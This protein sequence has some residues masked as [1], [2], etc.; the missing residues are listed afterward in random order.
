MTAGFYQT[1]LTNGLAY[2]DRTGRALKQ[3]VKFIVTVTD[4]K[5]ENPKGHW[6]VETHLPKDLPG[7]NA[8][9]SY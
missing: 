2:W 1:G 7:K 9:V 6:R 5:Q 8:S 4:N 3:T